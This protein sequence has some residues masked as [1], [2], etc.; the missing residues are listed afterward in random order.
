[1]IAVTVLWLEK[2]W[3]Y[4][5]KKLILFDFIPSLRLRLLVIAEVLS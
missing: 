3:D 1:M 2:V 4:R 5:K